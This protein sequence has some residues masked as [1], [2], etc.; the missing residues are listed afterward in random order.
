[1]QYVEDVSWGLV[2]PSHDVR[3]TATLGATITPGQNTPGSWAT[4]LAGGSLTD[5]AYMIEIVIHGGSTTAEARDSLTDIGV[6]PSGGTTPLDPPLIPSLLTSYSAYIG[7]N[8]LQGGIRYRFRV[9]IKAGSTIMARASVNNAT[10]RTQLVGV[11]VYCRPSSPNVK[12]GSFVVAYGA[13]AANSCGTAVTAGTASVGA[14]TQLGSAIAGRPQWDWCAAAAPINSGTIA[15]G[16]TMH[17]DMAVGDATTKKRVVYNQFGA[18]DTGERW[19]MFVTPT[20]HLGAIGDLIYARVWS[21]TSTTAFSA[22]AY[23][24]GG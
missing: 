22:I 23:G 3:P 10:V 19:G 16:Q 7:A 6:D 11:H 9:K 18:G 5:D 2:I 24:T 4:V 8:A 15:S 14:Y 13:N 21:G 12:S 17:V 20:H 1:M